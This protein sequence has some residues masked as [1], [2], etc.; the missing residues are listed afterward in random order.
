MLGRVKNKG[1]SVHLLS[2]RPC[3]KDLNTKSLIVIEIQL[4][5]PF[6]TQ[7]MADFIVCVTTCEAAEIKDAV[8]LKLR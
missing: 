1:I 2:F 7:S 8:T 6:F 5:A 3:F 4:Q